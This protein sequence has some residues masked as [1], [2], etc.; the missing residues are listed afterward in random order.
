MRRLLLLVSAV[1][2]VDA[3]FFA[4][5]TPLLA[6]YSNDLDLSKAGAG[7][8]SGAYAAGALVAGIPS[9]IASARFGVK[10]TLLGGLALMA[11][12]T[13]TFGFAE[14][15]VLLDVAR[16]LQGC[17]SAFA[18]T[19]GFAWLIAAAAPAR[20]GELI[21]AAMGAAIFGA[22]FGPVIGGIAALTS[23]EVAFGSVAFLAAL[24]GIWAW[25]TPSYAPT[26]R[27]P[28]SLLFGALR[29]RQIL[30]GGWLVALPA[31]FFGTLSVL[32]P[33][34]LDAFGFGALAIGA[35][36]LLTAALE[37]VISPVI[38]RVSDRRGRFLPLRA[39]LYAA[40][41]VTVLLPWMPNAWALATLVVL[42][43]VA[44]GT[45]WSPAMSLLA[46]RAEAR[47]LDHAYAF[48]LVNIAWAP[49]AAAGGAVGGGVAE[50][51][52]DAVP[53][54][55]LALAC[56]ATV[57]WLRRLSRQRATSETRTVGPGVP[58]AER[59]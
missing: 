33:L 9:A 43:G 19:A 15:I 28:L 21:G 27:Q 8:L 44:F 52:A 2:F 31:L 1:V 7:V 20:R 38:G 55:A 46:D 54:L 57:L 37:G 11:A 29:D 50:A 58:A 17:A 47:G 24:L 48:A 56:I 26:G 5:L 18:W 13:V 32:A 6:Q 40:I 3:M 35:T 16:F 36:W 45:F 59:R 53:Y 4:A 34:Q 49:G 25:R 42:S 39:G 12:T 23:T 14:N 51:T 10:P 30:T 22:M 41:P